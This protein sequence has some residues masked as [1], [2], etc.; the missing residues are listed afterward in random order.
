MLILQLIEQ[1]ST[2]YS[3]LGALYI[4]ISDIPSFTFCLLEQL[5]EQRRA[6][7]FLKIFMM[8]YKTGTL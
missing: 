8:D 3:N 6:Q 4:G 5:I 2:F 1:Y 7:S